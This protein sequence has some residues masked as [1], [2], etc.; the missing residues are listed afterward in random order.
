MSLGRSGL[1]DLRIIARGGEPRRTERNN[2]KNG[3]EPQFASLQKTDFHPRL[4]P[5]LTICAWDKYDRLNPVVMEKIVGRLHELPLWG[6]AKET[7]VTDGVFDFQGVTLADFVETMAARGARRVSVLISEKYG[8]P[9]VA[10]GLLAPG[11]G[12]TVGVTFIFEVSA[13]KEGRVLELTGHCS[14]IG[15][16][17]DSPEPPATIQDR[18][19]P[20]G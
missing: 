4:R 11:T 19:L 8:L 18:L 6:Q 1:V 13:R 5:F 3:Y 16:V 14:G 20:N 10:V 12:R 9:K 17:E 2:P 7:F 15:P